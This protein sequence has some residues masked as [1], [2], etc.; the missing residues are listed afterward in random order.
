[1]DTTQTTPQ[2]LDSDDE[3]ERQVDEILSN[4][5]EENKNFS[6]KTSTLL[7][8]MDHEVD[9]LAADIP[10]LEKDMAE[11]EAQGQKKMRDATE[12]FLSEESLVAEE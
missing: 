3:L 4:L 9:L 5:K 11:I 1:M 8:K 10:N 2:L 6:E 12:K 7:S